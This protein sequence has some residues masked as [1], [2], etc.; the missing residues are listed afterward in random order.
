MSPDWKQLV[1]VQLAP[2]R[3]QPERELEIVEELA[4]HLEAAYETALAKG[5]SEEA[6]Q[7]QALAQI[8][9]WPLLESELARAEAPAHRLNWALAAEP[10]VEQKGGMRMESLWQ[11]LRYGARML[12]K[13]PGFTLVAVLTLAL[14]IG[15]N[16][17]IF[18]VVNALLLRPLPYHEPDRLVLLSEK[19]LTGQGGPRW[20]L[21]Y[22]NFT[23]W[24]ERAQSFEGMASFRQTSFNLTGLDRPQLA[25]GRTV[26]WNF[27]RLLGVRPQ[28][29][30]L[31][32]KEDD[33]Y[34]VA[35]T[36]VISNGMW[37]ERFGGDAGVIGRKLLLDGEPYEVIGVLPPGFEYFRSDDVYVPIGLF[38][39]PN[40]PLVD[41]GSQMGLYAVAR[42]KPGFTVAQASNEMAGIAAQ[43]SSE[44]PNVNSGRS[45]QAEPL[46]DVMSESVRQ[47]LWVLLSAVGLILLIA[48]VNVANLL[49][50]RAAERQKELA[51]RLALGAGRGRVIRQLLSESLLIALLGGAFGVLTGRWMLDGLLARAPENIPQLSRVSLNLT[52]LLF[53][54]A[55][56]VLTSLLC[57]LLP[58]LH[59][60][61]TDLQTALKEGG[62]ST[63]GA[64]REVTRKTLLV[65]EV[66]LALVLLVAAGLLVR[67]MVRL[68]RV[69]PG[70][71]PD[72]LLTLKAVVPPPAY[73]DE[74]RRVFFDECLRRVSALPGVQ[75]AAI[76]FSLPIDGS[77][78]NSVF[79][80]ADKPIP[81]HPELP[82][83]ALTPVSAT[84]FETLS[85]RLLK[86]RAFTAADRADS[87]T[88]VMINETLA[89][90]IWPG[91]DPIGKRLKQGR[92]ESQTPWREVVG[93][94]ADVKL[95]GVERETPMQTYLPLAQ[96][97]RPFFALVVRTAGDPL[98]LAATVERTMH[99]I[100]KDLPVFGIRSMDQ[101]LGNSMAQRRLTLTL[102]VS[103][104]VLALLLAAVGI[105]GVIS[106]SVR[107]RTHELGI[108]MALGATAR[109]VLKLILSQGM[110]LALL[111]VG[112][113][114]LAAFALTRLMEKLLF[115]VDATDPLTFVVIAVGLLLVALLACLVPARRAT[116]VDPLIALRHE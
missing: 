78:W 86:G 38:L 14:G 105:Y 46:Q 22:P 113:G 85:I 25:W 9:D 34:G 96:S 84:Y 79:I 61:Q 103:F 3:L 36:V 20:I 35:R 24:R 21:S 104:A 2:L 49:L 11:D 19:S 80:A 56:S 68:L 65:V 92:P 45:A 16:T 13:N 12:G 15:A 32:A 52:V 64:G 29:G 73:D 54:F 88:V 102:L 89:R 58:A 115:K 28:L 40:M 83:S 70:F 106:Y 111:G 71:N 101:L 98:Q 10:W 59:A 81:P 1:R 75:S 116:Q 67:S 90:R 30:R 72:R 44:Y 39:R 69:D 95:N 63:A 27:F 37:R 110:K 53:T 42:L 76:T 100:D 66:S 97:P 43:L 31:F 18:S 74:R 112:I 108:R 5:L 26:N 4:L 55:V 60:S 114:L 8:T 77:N 57:G 99:S 41:R 48:C 17:A 87:A 6:A 47:S 23:D 82:N 107:Q 91:E 62:R 50:V 33:Q 109:D 51:L 94:V 7:A 93:V